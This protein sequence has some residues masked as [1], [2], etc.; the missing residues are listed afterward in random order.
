M[1]FSAGISILD[2]QR[3]QVYTHSLVVETSRGLAGLRYLLA[4]PAARRANACA[5]PRHRSFD[6][7]LWGFPM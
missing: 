1:L 6:R 4:T 3:V 7:G 5:S 2:F